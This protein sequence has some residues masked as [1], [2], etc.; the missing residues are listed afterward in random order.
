MWRAQPIARTDSPGVHSKESATEELA[1]ESN[2]IRFQKNLIGF[3]KFFS[4]FLFLEKCPITTVS[5]YTKAL[6]LGLSTFRVKFPRQL[7]LLCVAVP[8]LTYSRINSDTN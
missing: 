4:E 8:C 7:I 6:D 3:G 1:S 5:V 2:L